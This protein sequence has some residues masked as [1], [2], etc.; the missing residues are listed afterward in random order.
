MN[1]EGIGLGFKTI[2]SQAAPATVCEERVSN[3]PLATIGGEG[4]DHVMMRK[5][6]YLPG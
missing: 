3:V 4:R 2:K 1:E 5:P 6:G